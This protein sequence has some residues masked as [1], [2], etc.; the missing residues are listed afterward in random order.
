MF[1]TVCIHLP[2]T[3]VLDDLL[4]MSGPMTMDARQILESPGCWPCS[5]VSQCNPPVAASCLASGSGSTGRDAPA[6]PAIRRWQRMLSG[7]SALS[8]ANKLKH[9]VK[10]REWGCMRSAGD[11]YAAAVWSLGSHCGFNPQ[12]YEWTKYTIDR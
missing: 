8:L 5:R 4:A 2:T 9:R 7:C 6:L 12:I 11:L 3:A 1:G 10:E